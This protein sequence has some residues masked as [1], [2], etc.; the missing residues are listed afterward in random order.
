MVSILSDAGYPLDPTIWETAK[1]AALVRVRKHWD[2]W[3]KDKTSVNLWSNFNQTQRR[4]WVDPWH[5]H[6]LSGVTNEESTQYQMMQNAFMVYNW[7]SWKGYNIYSQCAILASATHESTITGGAWEHHFH[8][9]AGDN[10]ASL[11]GYDPSRIV[12]WTGYTDG[13]PNY[14]I[15]NQ[16]GSI[17]PGYTI[18]R[19]N[20]LTSMD[21]RATAIAGSYE[22]VMAYTDLVYSDW[23]DP[24]TGVWYRI[25][26]PRFDRSTATRH[27]GGYGLW[28]F[29]PW[30]KLP[31]LCIY[32][33]QHGKTYLDQGA[34]H[35]QLNLTLEL[36]LMEYMREIAMT[37][38][39]Q[40]SSPYYG[41]WYDG[42]S[43][44][45]SAS[46]AWFQWPFNP[47]NEWNRHYYNQ[48]CT[49]DEFASGAYL[50]WIENYFL[51]MSNPPVEEEDKE[52]CKRQL[53]MAIWRSNFIQAPYADFGF[54]QISLYHFKAIEYW[55]ANGGWNVLNIPRVRDMPNCE[56]DQYHLQDALLPFIMTKRRPKNARTLLF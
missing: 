33:V 42:N 12:S 24:N 52:W 54:E 55:N 16:S 31:A 43:A 53:A 19:P 56:L 47:D 34:N 39:S 46:S 21:V 25:P 44:G 28:Q 49:W 4:G 35:W 17:V 36:I 11:I 22:A 29:T 2:D 15:Y 10:L 8:P 37:P 51:T 48:S 41:Q 5:E 50:P 6:E 40:S 20:P 32:G 18:S 27:Y 9:Y 26:E 14:L 3:L 38:G 30:T 7:L 23:R 45:T 1:Q 13:A